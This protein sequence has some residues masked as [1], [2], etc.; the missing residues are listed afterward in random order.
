MINKYNFETIDL[1]RRYAEEWTH[2]DETTGKKQIEIYIIHV[3]FD[4]LSD[5]TEREYFQDIPT[6]LT[7]PEEQVDK[8]RRVAGKLLYAQEPFTRLV[9]DLGGRILEAGQT[10]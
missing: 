1:L 10:K 3:T 5:K 9:K 8:V 7:L 2:E 4:S 6:A